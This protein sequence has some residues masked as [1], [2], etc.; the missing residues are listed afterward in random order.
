MAAFENVNFAWA[1]CIARDDA[2]SLAALRLVNGIELAEQEAEIWIRGHRVEE[3]LEA[4]LSALPARGRYELMASNQLRQEGRRI[5][6]G[7]LPELSWLPLNMWLQVEPP[8]AALPAQAVPAATL[9]LVRSTEERISELL[10]TSFEDFHRFTAQ[11]AQVRLERLQFAADSKG[12]VLV[13]GAPLP[14]LPGKRFV[15]YGAVAVP[16][17]FAWQP[18]VSDEI[19]ARYFN[20]SGHDLALWNE[21][22]TF[23][24]LHGE[25]FVAVTRSAVRATKKAMAASK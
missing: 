13:R 9:Q 11:A 24:R 1:I 22:G 2:A 5:P 20:V 8:V 19:L 23:L 18:A 14:P 25:Q 16:A 6:S 7:R 17:G 21:D 4:K 10:L 12:N 15:L 3:A